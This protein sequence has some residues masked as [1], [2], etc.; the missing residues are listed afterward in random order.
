[1]T[2]KR[3]DADRS[4]RVVLDP[5]ANGDDHCSDRCPGLDAA[6]GTCKFFGCG[7]V[8]DIRRKLCV[9]YRADTCIDEEAYANSDDF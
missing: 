8:F 4:F 1:M 2:K 5:I 6:D 7:L 9:W 3:S